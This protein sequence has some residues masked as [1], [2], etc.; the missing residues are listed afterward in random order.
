MQL[1]FLVT[2][3]HPSARIVLGLPWL[4]E[5]NPDVDWT[6]MQLHIPQLLTDSTPTA[7]A[8]RASLN[9][10]LPDSP[11]PLPEPPRVDVRLVN[12]AAFELL[13][14]QGAT[15]FAVHARS[16]DPPPKP[17]R[18]DLTS[19]S[20]EELETFLANVPEEYHDFA[21]VFSDA[22]A[23][24]LPPHRPYDHHIDLEEGSR[25]PHGPIY[26]M[27]ETELRT[28]REYLDDMLGKG[29]IRSSSS[30]AGAPILFAKKK[31]GSLRLCVDYRGLN[32]ITKKNRYPIPLIND[33]LDRLRDARVF[34]KIDLRAGYNNI[35]IAEGDEWKTAF[36]TR[37][38][39]YEYLVM[40]FGMTNSPATFQ[41]FMNDIFSDMVDFFVVVY[42]D[43]ILIYSRDMA[44][45]QKH[46]RLVLQ[47]LRENN[48]HANLSKTTFHTDTV[49]Y[50]GFIVS[51][52]GISM[53]EAKTKVVRAWPEPHN[54][55][56][57]QSFLGFA[58]F[59]RR[60]IDNYSKIVTPLTRLTRKNEPFAWTAETQLA[61][62]TLKNAFCSAPV[63]AHYDPSLPCVLETDS[64]DYALGA[65]LSQI[66]PPDNTIHPIAF[67]SRTLSP[68]KRNYE[69][70]DKELNAIQD[71]FKHWRH[72]LEGAAP[73]PACMVIPFTVSTTFWRYM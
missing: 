62:D 5:T 23:T 26:S 43:D 9:A 49:E 34:T 69:I 60:F 11:P 65:V 13:Q 18:P 7:Q 53:D 4:Q 12:A 47:R 55:K 48:L 29:F 56:A 41:T 27:S 8:F 68:A 20:P 39:Q 44:E 50:L 3:L 46:V 54:V 45:H 10:P 40:P 63:L 59:Y 52:S 67:H 51:P 24:N 66:H 15:C 21:D 70:Y 73:V 32:R 1:T 36:R 2:K 58:N 35:R 57:V 64:S 28:V 61:F 22:E 42:L 6:N 71:S 37:Y 33:L 19:L 38:G 31:D 30:P 17:E 14:R 25:P 72:Y 16:L